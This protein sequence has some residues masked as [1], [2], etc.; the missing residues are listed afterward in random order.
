MFFYLNENRGFFRPQKY[1]EEAPDIYIGGD[2]K[3]G[4]CA[5]IYLTRFDV[6]K[7]TWS[8]YSGE[9]DNYLVPREICELVLN[10]I[11]IDDM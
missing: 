4:E 8:A 11:M 9:I 6:Y 7:R 3:K 1:K 2:P 5:R 10:D